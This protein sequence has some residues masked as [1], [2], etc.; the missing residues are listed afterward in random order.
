MV[1]LAKTGL[2]HD[3]RVILG[4]KRAAQRNRG[5]NQEAD[6]SPQEEALLT[7]MDPSCLH[8]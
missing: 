2:G 4:K 8:V 3:P 5:G 1:S 6:R 7:L